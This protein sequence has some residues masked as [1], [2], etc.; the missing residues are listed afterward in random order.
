M[1]TPTRPIDQPGLEWTLATAQT[2]LGE[3][4]FARIRSEAQAQSLDPLLRT[5]PN[6]V[7]AI[8]P[9]K[10]HCRAVAWQDNFPYGRFFTSYGHE[11][12][13]R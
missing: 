4:T 11:G 2:I 7:C 13:Q 10:G 9:I 5:I 3:E 8:L 1:E 6:I 12:L